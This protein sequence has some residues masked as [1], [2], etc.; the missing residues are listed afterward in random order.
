MQT[1]LYFVGISLD[2]ALQREQIRADKGEQEKINEDDIIRR[3]VNGIANIKNHI[4]SG[5]VDLIKVY[6]NSRSKGEEQLLLHIE[7]GDT[8]FYHPNPP[9]WFRNT[10]CI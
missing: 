7:K 5:N 1:E 9:E 4:E 2:T 3:Y 6:D 8:I 10:N